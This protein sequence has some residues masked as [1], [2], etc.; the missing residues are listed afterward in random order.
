LEE[1]ML[2][3][4]VFELKKSYTQLYNPL[5]LMDETF[6]KILD[7]YEYPKDRLRMIY[8]QLCGI[9]RFKN[10]DNQLE[11]LFDGRTHLEKFQEDWS[12]QLIQWVHELGYH[13]QY[14]KTML[15]MTLLF[16]TESRAEWSE[17]HCKFFIN[18]YF[19][20]KIIKRKGELKLKI[21]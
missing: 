11:L 2:E 7:T 20:L 14:V 21:A 5:M 4:M 3:V 18:E 13:E 17:N 6:A 16:D 15:R 19:E 8:R 9:Y 1:Q 10:K 12:L